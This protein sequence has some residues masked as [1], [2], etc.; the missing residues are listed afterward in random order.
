[1]YFSTSILMHAYTYNHIHV[2]IHVNIHIRPKTSVTISLSIYIKNISHQC[3]QFQLNTAE[4]IMSFS[5]S[6]FVTSFHDT[7]KPGSHFLQYGYLFVL[8]KNTQK[9]VFRIVNP[10]LCE[11]E[12]YHIPTYCRILYLA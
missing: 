12:T 6:I 9:V 2:C 8:I 3:L 1:M 5:F 11:K 4:F 10:F 7:K